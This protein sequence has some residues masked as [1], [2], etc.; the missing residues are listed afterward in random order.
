MKNDPLEKFPDLQG[1]YQADGN[2]LR[3]PRSKSKWKSNIRLKKIWYDVERKTWAIGDERD[4]FIYIR[5]RERDDFIMPCEE[6]SW[7]FYDFKEEWR[8][9]SKPVGYGQS[10][11]AN[12]I[13]IQCI[14]KV[15]QGNFQVVL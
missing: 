4:N 6:N 15:Q 13:N 8:G 7:F 3:E 11:E 12:D 14:G 9:F 1:T 2:N 10:G 5:G